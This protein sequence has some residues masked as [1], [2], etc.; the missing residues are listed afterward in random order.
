MMGVYG[1]QPNP[2][3]RKGRFAPWGDWDGRG[4]DRPVYAVPVP[5]AD[6]WCGLLT[7]PLSSVAVAAH[8]RWTTKPFSKNRAPETPGLNRHMDEDLMVTPAGIEPALPA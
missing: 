6:V 5:A 1:I 2:T 4:T 8:C 3:D 7:L